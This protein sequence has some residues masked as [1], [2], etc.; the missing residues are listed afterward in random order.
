MG[1]P[2]TAGKR[3]PH[4]F[5]DGETEAQGSLGTCPRS[6]TVSQLFRGRGAAHTLGNMVSQGGRKGLGG[7]EASTLFE[8]C[9]PPEMDLCL[10]LGVPSPVQGGAFWREQRFW[11][12]GHPLQNFRLKRVAGLFSSQVGRSHPYRFPTKS[13]TPK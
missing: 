1:G 8:R 10:A 3:W 4:F 7:Q 2:A 12:D 9:G 5:P 13:S 11:Q 6:L